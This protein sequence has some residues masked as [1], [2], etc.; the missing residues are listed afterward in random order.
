MKHL[1]A[2]GS[3]TRYMNYTD[4]YGPYLTADFSAI[5]PYTK[6]PYVLTIPQD[7]TE[8]GLYT[9]VHDLGIPMFRHQKA[10]GLRVLDGEGPYGLEVAFE[11]GY[12]IRAEHIVAADGKKSFVSCASRCVIYFDSSGNYWADSVSKWPYLQRSQDWACKQ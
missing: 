5:S 7:S 8:Q 10:V 2:H 9:H 4:Q 1:V 3:P 12:R 11:G 6:Y